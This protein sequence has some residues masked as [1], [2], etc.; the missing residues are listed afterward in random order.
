VVDF[1]ETERFGI[2]PNNSDGDGDMLPDKQ[3]IITGI[4]DPQYGYATTRGS[5]FGRDYDSDGV[6]T[7]RDK[8]SDEGG[9]PDGKEDANGNGHRDGSETYNFDGDDDKDSQCVSDEIVLQGT[10]HGT[11]TETPNYVNTIPD[12]TTGQFEVTMEVTITIAL[13]DWTTEGTATVSGEYT[14]DCEFSDADSGPMIKS[15]MR[16]SDPADPT[17]MIAYVEVDSYDPRFTQRPLTG[18]YL[19]VFG[20]TANTGGTCG[21]TLGPVEDASPELQV[22]LSGCNS[23]EILNNNGTWHG[24]CSQATDINPGTGRPYSEQ[25]WTANLEQISPRETPPP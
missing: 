7:E 10:I 24:D 23:F 1:D 25:H 12:Q 16:A 18:L 21:H 20:R 13:H 8:D 11:G 14:G 4:F 9:C 2:N 15:G 6:P 3:D 19:S 5:A 17:D 22:S